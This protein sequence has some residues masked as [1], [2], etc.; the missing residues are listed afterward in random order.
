MRRGLSVALRISAK[1][2]VRFKPELWK[3]VALAMSKE[4][5]NL[6]Q[7]SLWVSESIESIFKHWEQSSPQD[8]ALD[9]RTYAPAVAHI[10]PS[11]H[12]IQKLSM[13]FQEAGI[14]FDDLKTRLVYAAIVKRLNQNSIEYRSRESGSIST[15]ETAQE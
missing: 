3:A 7:R 5:Y 6:K 9:L 13:R 15:V 1:V 14:P 2:S 4:N 10:N 11:V 12:R 8:I